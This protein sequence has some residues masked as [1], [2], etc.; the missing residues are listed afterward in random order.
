VPPPR[1]HWLLAPEFGPH[2]VQRDVPADG[3]A[4][5]RRFNHHGLEAALEEVAALAFAPVR[6]HC[7][8]GQQRLHERGQG[9][10]TRHQAKL[11][12]IWHQAVRAQRDIIDGGELRQFP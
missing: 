10:L 7:E 4:P 11:E 2:R 3:H 5:G 1:R 9:G 6:A 12:V 8:C